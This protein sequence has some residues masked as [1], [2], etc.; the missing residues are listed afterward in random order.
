MSQEILK[1]CTE[2]GFLLD[3]EVLG[4]L[5]EIED[6]ELAKL[7]IE[8]VR[9]QTQ[10]KIIT[11]DVFENEESA[12]RVLS[13]IPER[14]GKVEKLKI[15]LGLNI[16]ISR[17]ISPKPVV[18]KKNESPVKVTL[19]PQFQGKK[20]EVKDFVNYFRNRF[21][22]MKSFVQQN[23]KLDNLTSIDK[24]YGGKQGISV[25]GMIS[26]KRVTKNNN[27]MF[28]I[29]DLTGKIKVVINKDKEELFEIAEEI[30]LDSVIG[31]KGSGNKE[32]IFANEVI[33]PECR[34]EERKRSP[35][36]EYAIFI[37]DLHFGSKLFFDRSFNKFID[38]LNG[39]VP[40]TPEVNKIKYLYI[41]GDLVTGVGNYPGQ[42]KDLDIPDLEEQFI[43][44]SELL[45]KIRKDIK[46]IISPGNHDCVRLMEPQPLLDEKYAWPLYNMENVILTTNPAG[47]NMGST[48]NFS[49]FNV[50]T[51]HGF[52]FPYYADNVPRLMKMKAMNAPENIMKYLLMHRHLAP[53]HGSLQYFPSEEDTMIIKEIPD[54]IVSGH[55]HKSAVTYHNNILVISVSCWQAMTAY[56]EKLGAKPDQCKVPLFNLKTRQIKIL[57]FEDPL[58][59]EE[60]KDT[61]LS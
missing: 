54:I 43:Q 52:S 36:D 15:K 9:I 28:E 34:L 59:R 37:G 24:I 3:K 35:V 33:L 58:D 56:Q 48:D 50:L 18:E 30:A 12:K 55:T 29:E 5:S 6:L 49:G 1:F 44:L 45:G 13:S 32:I 26:S 27:L 31:F 39:K 21:N 17:E 11:K 38:Y 7:I 46:I 20:L 16:E 8:K 53:T 4:L 14:N 42:E 10:K 51:Y 40:N 22:E 2:K 19:M 61:G 23:S 25:I 47:I 60:K 57:D 41:V